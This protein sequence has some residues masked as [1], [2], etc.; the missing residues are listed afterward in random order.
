M[1]AGN[2]TAAVRFDGR[3]FLSHKRL[4]WIIVSFAV[5]VSALVGVIILEAMTG[6]MSGTVVHVRIDECSPHK[7][8]MTGFCRPGS[9]YQFRRDD[10]PKDSIELRPPAMTG[11]LLASLRIY[12]WEQPFRSSPCVADF[13]KPGQVVYYVKTGDVISL[14]LAQTATLMSLES[15]RTAQRWAIVAHADE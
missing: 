4:W 7:L 12:L 10:V 3:L 11:P 2:D 8:A 14:R 6:W 1:P 9:T 5:L 13:D 15:G